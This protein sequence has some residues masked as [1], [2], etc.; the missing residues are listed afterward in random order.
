MDIVYRSIDNCY[1]DTKE[2][3][4]AHEN[5]LKKYQYRSFKFDGQE[6]S[7]EEFNFS[8]DGIL[9]KADI[10]LITNV[11]QY[12]KFI[13]DCIDE[14]FQVKDYENFNYITLEEVE[15]DFYRGE[16]YFIWDV[17]EDKFVFCDKA[18]LEKIVTFYNATKE[19]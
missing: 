7:I 13:K 5:N 8:I 19:N 12:Y 2:E 17:N 16:G 6:I 15:E 3:C 11:E 14:G 10:I 18:F 4:I 9:N 1:F